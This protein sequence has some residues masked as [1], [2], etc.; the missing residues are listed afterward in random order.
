MNQNKMIALGLFVVGAILLYFG[1]NAANAP[2]EELA[3]A[4]TGQYSDQ[5]MFYLVGGG[6]AAVVGFVM[7]LRK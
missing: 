1:Y 5:T 4:M 3:E 7:L 6:A 2:A